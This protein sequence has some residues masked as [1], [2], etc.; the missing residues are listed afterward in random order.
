MRNTRPLILFRN[1]RIDKDLGHVRSILKVRLGY[2]FFKKKELVSRGVSLYRN[3]LSLC[4]P[5]VAIVIASRRVLVRWTAVRSRPIA[6]VRSRRALGEYNSGSTNVLSSDFE[7][8][9]WGILG[10]AGSRFP[11]RQCA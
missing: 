10:V 8:L 5:I 2:R 11:V 4:G 6:T 7:L 3:V 9:R 1:A